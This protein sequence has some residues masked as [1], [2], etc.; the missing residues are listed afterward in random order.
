MISSAPLIA[1]NDLPTLEQ[2]V[3]AFLV[4]A[5]AKAADG[6]TVSEFAEL[7]VAMLRV[8]MDAVESVPADGP[9]K[10]QWVINAIGLLFDDLA[11]QCVPVYVWPV[12]LVVKPLVRQLVLAAASGAVESLLPLVRI[13]AR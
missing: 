4:I 6:L 11:D 3:K 10:K 7:F 5:R 13:A 8:A 9:A 12:W 1:A 2:K